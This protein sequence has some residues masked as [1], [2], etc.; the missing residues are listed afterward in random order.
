M[1]AWLNSTIITSTILCYIHSQQ[2][3][4]QMGKLIACSVQSNPKVSSLQLHANQ[5]SMMYLESH[6]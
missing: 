4:S 3:S 5:H 2:T 6:G 1:L